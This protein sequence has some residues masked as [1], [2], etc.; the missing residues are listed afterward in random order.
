VV[1]HASDKGIEREPYGPQRPPNLRRIPSSLEHAAAVGVVELEFDL[2]GREVSDG[3]GPSLPPVAFIGRCDTE[4]LELLPAVFGEPES[5]GVL[6]VVSAA[7]QAEDPATFV[8]SLM[9]LVPVG[10][11]SWCFDYGLNASL[12][13]SAK[14]R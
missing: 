3:Q 5:E 11:T 4:A 2:K 13:A 6:M 7:G 12:F 1:L 10:D 9:A 8:G 14:S